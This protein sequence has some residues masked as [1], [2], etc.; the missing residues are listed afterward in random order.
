MYSAATSAPS[1]Q[2]VVDYSPGDSAAAVQTVLEQQGLGRIIHAPDG[3]IIWEPLPEGKPVDEGGPLH[4]LAARKLLGMLEVTASVVL[5]TSGVVAATSTW[6][7]VDRAYT[8]GNALTSGQLTSAVTHTVASTVAGLMTGAVLGPVRAASHLV[9]KVVRPLAVGL[10]IHRGVIWARRNL[11]GGVVSLIRRLHSGDVRKVLDALRTIVTCALSEVFRKEFARFSGIQAL[12]Q[13]LADTLAKAGAVP[14]VLPPGMAPGGALVGSTMFQLV[15]QALEALL[16]SAECKEACLAA[17]GAPLLVSCLANICASQ[18]PSLHSTVAALASP[19][20]TRCMPRRSSSGYTVSSFD[21]S[22]DLSFGH[23]A[24]PG[25][26]STSKQCSSGT[27]SADPACLALSCLTHL[28]MLP[29]ARN[30]IRE[31]G[32]VPIIVSFLSKPSAPSALHAVRL[33]QVMSCDAASKDD[34]GRSGGMPALVAVIES[35]APYSQTQADA[36]AALESLIKGS[37]ANQL[38]LAQVPGS[39]PRLSTSHAVLGPVCHSSKAGLQA[40]MSVL[41]RFPDSLPCHHAVPSPSGTSRVAGVDAASGAPPHGDTGA[42][43]IGSPVAHTLPNEVLV[44]EDEA[45]RG[46]SA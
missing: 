29:A 19:T 9:S 22:S 39:F 20:P 44:Y 26:A 13:L 10:V 33:V 27:G 15:L 30:S 7:H 4:K 40:L 42:Q 45:W 1:A 18:P 2:T 38:A 12:L 6:Q 36:V 14:G 37:P 16:H 46:C 25:R 21:G 23:V 43:T 41:S 17:G 32:G 35:S 34:I 3:T 8:T 24:G 5:A 11:L 31:E 28:A